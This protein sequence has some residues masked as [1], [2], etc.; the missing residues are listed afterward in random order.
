MPPGQRVDG[1][2]LEPAFPTLI[3]TAGVQVLR[4]KARGAKIGHQLMHLFLFALFALEFFP[5][6]TGRVPL[7][8]EFYTQIDHLR[9]R[10]RT[11]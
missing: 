9:V 5:Q 7:I 10:T 8:L 1:Q 2:P 4:F 6:R 11:V 3:D